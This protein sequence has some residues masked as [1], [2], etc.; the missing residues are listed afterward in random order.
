MMGMPN[1]SVFP[2]PVEA[3]PIT[4]RPLMIEGIHALWMGVGVEKPSFEI[5]ICSSGFK[6]RE[7]HAETSTPSVSSSSSR[8]ANEML[9][10]R[11]VSF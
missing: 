5:L 1:A 11:P 4:S 3:L 8:A 7:S 9:D 10:W 6:L 2:E